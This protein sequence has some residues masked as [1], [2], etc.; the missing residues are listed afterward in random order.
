MSKIIEAIDCIEE[1]LKEV[2]SGTV[3]TSENVGDLKKLM[4]IV[5]ELRDITI[6]RLCKIGKATDV[7]ELFNLS[8]ARVSQICTE[9]SN[10]NV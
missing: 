2:K 4:N 9:Y 10:K 6:F 1:L 3:L 8:P 7:A 5:R